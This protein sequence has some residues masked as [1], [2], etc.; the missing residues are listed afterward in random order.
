MPRPSYNPADLDSGIAALK[1]RFS[2]LGLT[3]A[4]TVSAPETGAVAGHR[5]RSKIEKQAEEELGIAVLALI[6]HAERVPRSFADNEGGR[7][8]TVAVSSDPRLVYMDDGQAV[9]H[10]LAVRDDKSQVFG[11]TRMVELARVYV[12]S[13]AHAARLKSALDSVLLGATGKAR[14]RWRDIPVAFDMEMLPLLIGQAV[15]D[16]GVACFDSVERDRRKAVAMKRIER[17]G[18]GK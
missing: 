2:G 12:Q 3:T 11:S 10:G 17:K 15:E 4:D 8:V 14:H 16:C 18:R 7:G 9:E 6:G 5:R 13:D 1:A